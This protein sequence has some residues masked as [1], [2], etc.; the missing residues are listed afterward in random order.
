MARFF[1]CADTVAPV[2]VSE[3]AVLAP[4]TSQLLLPLPLAVSVDVPVVMLMDEDIPDAV[5]R[6]LAALEPEAASDAVAIEMVDA[7]MV[8]AD[9]CTFA[10]PP[11]QV[12]AELPPTEME[13]PVIVVA[14][15]MSRVEPLDAVSDAA[16]PMVIP[17][18]VAAERNASTSPADDSR[19]EE[20]LKINNDVEVVP[21]MAMDG[22]IVWVQLDAPT[23][24]VVTDD[25]A[26]FT[27]M[28][29]APVSVAAVLVMDTDDAVA[30]RTFA[31]AAPADHVD[32]DTRMLEDVKV[33]PWTSTLSIAADHT[34][35]D[36]ATM[37]LAVR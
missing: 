9:R 10:P 35:E 22:P 25:T 30:R 8:V 1:P 18:V 27:R 23:T 15:L 26:P 29:Y 5:R 12:S 4:S 3:T 36:E 11:A 7:V 16:L 31:P 24:D 13:T 34:D 20:P 32:E 2:A 33:V 14:P 6:T 19:V 21:Q 28:P 17:T 37:E